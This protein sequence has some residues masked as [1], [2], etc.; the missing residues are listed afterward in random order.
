MFNF[1]Q[2]HST[3]ICFSPLAT[4]IPQYNALLSVRQL[5]MRTMEI[6][7]QNSLVLEEQD[8]TMLNSVADT[9]ACIARLST[10]LSEV[11]LCT[12]LFIKHYTD[13]Y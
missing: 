4:L 3:L 12:L 11:S 1:V 9:G 7:A 6:N 5:A 2:P 10:T 13:V 8:K